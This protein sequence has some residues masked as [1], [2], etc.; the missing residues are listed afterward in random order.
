[1]AMD[2][3]NPTKQ[4]TKNKQQQKTP[5]QQNPRHINAKFYIQFQVVNRISEA[6]LWIA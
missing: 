2:Q 6:N 5:E 1:M 3:K 4:K